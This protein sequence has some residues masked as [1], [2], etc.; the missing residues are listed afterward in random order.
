MFIKLHMLIQYNDLIIIKY[1]EQYTVQGSV[2]FKKNA[3]SKQS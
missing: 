2:A 3:I 1:T